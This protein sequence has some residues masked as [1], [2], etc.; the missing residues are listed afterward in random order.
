MDLVVKFQAQRIVSGQGVV[1]GGWDHG[2]HCAVSG[3][4]APE[5][6]RTDR[7]AIDAQASLNAALID[8]QSLEPLPPGA[9][10]VLTSRSNC[11]LVDRVYHQRIVEE[12]AG[13]ASRRAFAATIPAAP[14]CEASIQLGLQGPLLAFVDGPE[15]GLEEAKRLVRHGRCEVALAIHVE[16]PSADGPAVGSCV[17]VTA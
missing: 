14:I 10:L 6:F 5:G 4:A 13:H 15:L 3:A 7:E 9:A 16:A 8:A 2:S 11:A 17:R 1:G 12:G